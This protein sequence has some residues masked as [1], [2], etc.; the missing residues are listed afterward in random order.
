MKKDKIINLLFQIA[1]LLCFLGLAFWLVYFVKDIWSDFHAKKTSERV[2]TERSHFYEHPAITICFDPLVNPNALN[3]YNMTVTEF[4]DHNKN[5]NISPNASSSLPM[6]KFVQDVGYKFD[7]DF[8]I[9]FGFW[10]K[11]RI[12]KVKLNGRRIPLNMTRI[13]KVKEII[14]IANGL[15]YIISIDRSI[16]SP[17][18]I[19]NRFDLKFED[20][21]KQEDLPHLEI[22]LTSKHNAYGAAI[23]QFYEGDRFHMKISPTDRMGTRISVKKQ[24]T[25]QLPETSNC[26]TNSNLYACWGMK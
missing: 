9:S 11:S 12:L 10:N 7:R 17:L 6:S 25:K 26:S 23:Y 3:K 2:Y 1:R 22:F 8:N 14:T 24:V 21:I 15:C 16:R 18:L 13:M 4:L 5:Y 20:K 19:P